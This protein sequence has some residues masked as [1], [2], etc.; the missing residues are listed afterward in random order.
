M[1][2]SQRLELFK[3]E[4]GFIKNSTIKRIVE[5]GIMNLPEYFFTV[6]ASSTGKYHPQYALGDGGLLRHTKGATRIANHL[7]GLE[8]YKNEFSEDERDIILSALI[9]HD[10]WKQ[11]I[12]EEKTSS[13]TTFNHPFDCA[14]WI[15]YGKCF[16]NL[17][18]D[19]RVEVGKLIISHMGEW[20]KG[21]G[22]DKDLPKPT[23]NAQKFVHMCD[24]LASRKDI[25][26]LFDGE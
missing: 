19:Y 5:V 22:N 20:N 14:K 16:E 13:F 12:K 11:G 8:Q 3:K 4:L 24:Y 9:L 2:D 18:V 7:L 15:V 6:P 26:V 23:T 1:N 10:G 17:N 21:K 25:E